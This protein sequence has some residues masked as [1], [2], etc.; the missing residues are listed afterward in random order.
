MPTNDNQ[1]LI[2][3]LM[4]CYNHELYIEEAIQSIWDQPN[5]KEIEIVAIDDG[6]K[7][8]TYKKLQQL[9]QNSPITM[10]IETKENE[11]ITKTLNHALSLA[12][13]KYISV[14]ASDD[15]YCEG[16]F[17]PL[18]E[19]MQN[20]NNL[21]VIYGNGY[22]FSNEGLKD[23]VH[24]EW[25]QSLLQQPS[26][27]VLESILQTVPR[28]LL[29]QC[30]LFDKEMLLAFGGWDEDVKLDD[31]PLNIKIF[32]YLSQNNYT[33]TYIEHCVAMYREHDQQIHV[34]I[35]KNYEMIIEVIQKYAPKKIKNS[36]L[37]SETRHLAK[38]F[39]NN[40][41]MKNA[42]HYLLLSIKYDK[43]FYNLIESVR[44]M[45]KYNLKRL[46]Q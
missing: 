15:K 18:L 6:S 17:I 10:T 31:W 23:K 28:P 38:Y 13:G 26:Q 9:Q 4:P 19:K 8:N 42:N 14:L 22:S 32:Q 34:Q 43:S 20:N 25:T 45:I 21:K 44:L 12:N 27:K 46:F 41:Q 24:T 37:S 2:S 35:L 29:T 1:P 36:F 11:G 7:D 33:H 3:V 40:H 16:A 39:I 5:A 30:A